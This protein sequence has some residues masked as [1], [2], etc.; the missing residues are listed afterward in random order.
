[1]DARLPRD[2]CQQVLRGL[3]LGQRAHQAA[4]HFLDFYTLTRGSIRYLKV[5]S[6]NKYP[7]SMKTPHQA[8]IHVIKLPASAVLRS[9]L[10]LVSITADLGSFTVGFQ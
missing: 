7:I 3:G 1:M 6:T 8:A 4:G 2:G 5:L 10:C 9:L